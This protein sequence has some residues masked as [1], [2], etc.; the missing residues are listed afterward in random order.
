M[1][2]RSIAR[3]TPSPCYGD[4]SLA[5]A[6]SMMLKDDVSILP[7]VES[8]SGRLSGVIT[9]RDVAMGA[10]TQGKPLERIPVRQCCSHDPHTCRMDDDFKSVHNTMRRYQVRRLPVIDEG[11]RVLAFVTLDD[12]AILACLRSDEVRLADLAITLGGFCHR[13]PKIENHKLVAAEQ[14]A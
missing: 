11:G 12:L 2:V 8:M 14:G 3:E 5:E 6:A 13:Q 9:D 1:K 10:L 4:T 7:V